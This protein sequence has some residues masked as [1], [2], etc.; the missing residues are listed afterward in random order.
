MKR[1]AHFPFPGTKVDK[2]IWVIKNLHGQIGES[3]FGEKNEV[4]TYALGLR[5]PC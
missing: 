1:M 4:M 2:A 5:F 3:W